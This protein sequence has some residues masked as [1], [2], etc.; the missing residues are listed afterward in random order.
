MKATHET[1]VIGKYNV[2]QICKQ[3]LIGFTLYKADS[4]L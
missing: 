3:F 1:E 2:K 4:P